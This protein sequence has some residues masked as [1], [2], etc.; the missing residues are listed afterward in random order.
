[1]AA[2]TAGPAAPGSG[3]PGLDAPPPLPPNLKTP[4]Y[5]GLASNAQSNP[6][7]PPGGQRAAMIV[8]QG[9]LAVKVLQSIQQVAPE[10]APM[11]DRIAQELQAALM[12]LVSPQGP[13]SSGGQPGAGPA[14]PPA[15]GPAPPPGA[16]AP[17][18]PPPQ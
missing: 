10:V 2:V 4:D 11:L 16:G 7:M 14:A 17:P 3:K 15:G 13:P 18:A 8:Q 12:P 1:M 6:Q 9:A 5:S